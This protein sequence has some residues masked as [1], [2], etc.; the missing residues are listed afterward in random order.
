PALV[1]RSAAGRAKRIGFLKA[2]V[3]VAAAVGADSVAIWS[4]AADDNASENALQERLTGALSEV[5]AH[6]ESAGVRLSFEP[7]PG[8]FIDTMARFQDLMKRVNHPLLGLTLDIGH[9]HCL[10]DGNLRDH[11]RRWRH[12]LW[13]VH[14]DDMRRNVHEHLMFGEG[15]VDFDSVFDALFEVDYAGPV[16]VEL[17]RHSHNAVETARLAHEFLTRC[18]N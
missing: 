5:L 11:I 7:E 15:E 13:N 4:G 12:V 3:D 6:A 17:P 16:H 8:M 10:N 2:A 9:V 14:L 18:V 1:S